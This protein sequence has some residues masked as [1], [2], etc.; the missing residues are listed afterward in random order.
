MVTRNGDGVATYA[1]DPEDRVVNLL[2]GNGVQTTNVY[3][4][5][6]RMLVTAHLGPGGVPLEAVQYGY[7]TVGRRT[8]AM[9][10][11]DVGD[12]FAYDALDQVT[13]VVYD[14]VRP[15]VNLGPGSGH[16]QTKYDAMGNRDTFM[17]D[18]N[19]NFYTANGLNQ[20]TAIDGAA[21]TYDLD[22]NLV[23]DNQGRTL[24]WD[25]ENRLRSVAPISPTNGSVKVEM[26]Y[27]DQSR[28]VGKTV[29]IRT[30][31]VWVQQSETVFTYQGWNLISEIRSQGSAVS[32][33]VYIWG[34]DLSGS[35]QGAG[36]VGGLLCSY[37]TLSSSLHYFSY[38]GNG[39]VILL[40]DAAGAV[41]G[42]YR[43]EAFGALRS[44]TGL[45]AVENPFRF[46]TKYSD[47]ET[48]LV[49][50]G[51]RYY[52]PKFGRWLSCD[53]MEEGGGLNL[54]AYVMNRP[55]DWHD[56]F[57]LAACNCGPDI[58]TSLTAAMQD[59]ER[60]FSSAPWYSKAWGCLGFWLPLP[61][62]M[63]NWDLQIDENSSSPLCP[64]GDECRHT[65]TIAG[66]CH[67]KWEVNY[68]LYGKSFSLCA[69]S[70]RAMNQNIVL[71]NTIGTAVRNAILRLDG[72][73]SAFD[74]LWGDSDALV[75]WTPSLH[76][77]ATIGYMN[78][79][80]S[81]AWQ[82]DRYKD[83]RPCSAQGRVNIQ[84]WPW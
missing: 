8:Y 45:A 57:G 56:P 76:A 51:F 68:I 2:R 40:T 58:T 11:D 79:P 37:S 81:S 18:A 7:D 26:S 43:Y 80:Y 17:T 42:R 28:R 31:G 73:A 15:D 35:L 53:P 72:N 74:R 23:F 46:S 55:T 5:V 59:A 75:E 63:S 27:D 1:Y 20:Y 6:G 61:S 3:D 44:M 10:G 64:I 12:R 50:Y 62:S 14:I 77:W 67:D 24:S 65:V 36:G 60:R 41:A 29:S 21:L 32:T 39:N 4:A 69:G 84:T 30:N 34:R 66:K 25:G 82:P 83:C 22:G 52:N 38:D 47:D 9:F 48:G 49:Y 70:F 13:G 78:L 16:E 71:W 54:Y 19:T 33:N